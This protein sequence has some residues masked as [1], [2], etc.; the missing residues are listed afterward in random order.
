MGFPDL[1]LDFPFLENPTGLIVA[2]IRRWFSNCISEGGLVE[3]M[4]L[5]NVGVEALCIVREAIDNG[6]PT[7][8]CKEIRKAVRNAMAS[9]AWRQWTKRTRKESEFSA[10]A[11]PDDEGDEGGE[12][13]DF[14]PNPE[15]EMPEEEV[16]NSELVQTVM[17]AVGLNN[18]LVEKILFF[19][20]FTNLRPTGIADLVQTK[21]EVIARTL[22]IIFARAKKNKQLRQY[23]A[24]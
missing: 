15:A 24:A 22:T 14:Y 17:A 19:A 18:E 1:S 13:T 23:L 2:T 11:T 8:T 10:F 6:Q 9:V 5:F 20:L 21:V 3:S 16:L 4:D 7:P 12:F